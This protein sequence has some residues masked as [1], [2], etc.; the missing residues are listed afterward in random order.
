MQQS[1]LTI[2]QLSNF[3]KALSEPVR[4]RMLALIC[5]HP[6]IVMSEMESILAITQTATSRHLMHLRNYGVV[7]NNRN[8]RQIHYYIDKELKPAI[9]HA[10]SLLSDS[11][12]QSD[13]AALLRLRGNTVTTKSKQKEKA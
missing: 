11:E 7:S 4:V 9:E 2:D 3:G 6:G 12:K 8:G 1:N 13:I 5:Q 10:I